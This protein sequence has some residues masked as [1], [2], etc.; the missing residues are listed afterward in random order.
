[1]KK[2]H[3]DN[4]FMPYQIRI[5]TSFEHEVLTKLCSFLLNNGFPFKGTTAEQGMVTELLTLMGDK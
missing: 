1:M 2:V 4:E 3:L 5:E